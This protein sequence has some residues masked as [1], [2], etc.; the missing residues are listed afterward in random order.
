MDVRSGAT[1]LLLAGPDPIGPTQLPQEVHVLTTTQIDHYRT[2]GF[3]VLP[4]LLGTERTAA[5][6][7]EVDVALRDAYS[8][9]YDER[10]IDGI[11]GHYLPMAS[12]HTPTSASLVCDDPLLIGVVAQLLGGP[13]IP[14]CPE[15]VLY[16]AQAGWHNDDGFG[17]TG[18]KFA[19]YF[20]PLDASNGALRFL[21]GSQSSEQNARLTAYRAR[22]HTR[23]AG[24]RRRLVTPT[25]R[26]AVSGGPPGR[27][28]GWR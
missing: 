8:T 4:G 23:P 28:T 22:R 12:R 18:V 13:A 9:T 25:E 7:T 26:A 1:E 6:R 27:G 2:F 10:V 16:F 5:L 11:S 17:V 20:D 21:P 15:G 14:E 3:V 24:R 19:T